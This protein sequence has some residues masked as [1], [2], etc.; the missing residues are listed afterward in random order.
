MKVCAKCGAQMKDDAKFCPVCGTQCMDGGQMNSN[1]YQN[2]NTNPYQNQ[3]QNQGGGQYYQAPVQNPTNGFAIASLV[4]GICT[5]VFGWFILDIPG[6]LAIIFGIVGMKQC[7]QKNMG[8]RGMA[9]AGLVLGIIASA[10]YFIVLI[11]AMSAWNSIWSIGLN[12]NL[13]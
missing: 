5:F 1:P 6:I 9:I 7:T 12:Y 13:Y 11:A 10:I 4:L 2:Q 8:G 3:N